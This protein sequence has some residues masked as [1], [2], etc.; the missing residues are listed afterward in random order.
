MTQSLLRH[1]RTCSYCGRVIR[2]TNASILEINYSLHTKKHELQG[3]SANLLQRISRITGKTSVKPIMYVVGY[4]L[5]GFLADNLYKI[6]MPWVYFGFPP[7]IAIITVFFKFRAG[8]HMLTYVQTLRL[9]ADW[10]I[11]MVIGG[12]VGAF[13]NLVVGTAPFYT[14]LYVLLFWGLYFSLIVDMFVFQSVLAKAA[15]R[16]EASVGKRPHFGKT[17]H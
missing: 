12:L 15:N 9:C 11:S 7:V 14:N 8:R 2:G 4:A 13:V 16:A 5:A 6:A 1:E 17:S 3:D 10:L